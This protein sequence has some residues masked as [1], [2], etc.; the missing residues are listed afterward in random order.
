[1]AQFKTLS[2]VIGAC[3]PEDDDQRALWLRRV[4][5]WRTLGKVLPSAPDAF[6]GEGRLRRYNEETIPL[7]AVL[8]R[9]ADHHSPDELDAISRLIEQNLA[10]RLPF[11]RHWRTATASAG[12]GTDPN[13]YLTVAYPGP[14]RNEFA[15]R[16][17]PSPVF[18]ADD[19]DVYVIH[20]TSIFGILNVLNKE[21]A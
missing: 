13:I 21:D 20:L 12:T 17:G 18:L 4:R 1:M 7:I 5:H 14:A 10:R 19:L 3:Q 11:A 2:Y 8:L 15:V 16:C 6:R 9:S